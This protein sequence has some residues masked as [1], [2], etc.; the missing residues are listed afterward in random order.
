MSQQQQSTQ[1][2]VYLPHITEEPTGS[3]TSSFPDQLCNS[4]NTHVE[5]IEKGQKSLIH[6]AHDCECLMRWS[7][8]LF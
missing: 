6:E 2:S 7:T 5:F 3:S 4:S 1:P 8:D